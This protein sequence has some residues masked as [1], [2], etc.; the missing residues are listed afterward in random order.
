MNKKRLFLVLLSC[1]PLLLL[2]EEGMWMPNQLQKKEAEMKQLGLRIPVEEIYS[3]V[4]VSLK[5][6]VVLFGGGC[7]GEI[8]SN[9]GLV[10][11]NHHCG[12]S[13]IQSKSTM[14]HNYVQDGF[15]AKS[16]KDELPCPGLTVTFTVRIENVTE[17]ILSALA[18][19]MSPQEREK[20]I[21]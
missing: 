11:T 6:A 19:E 5:D 21:A 18:P 8:I 10:L 9:Q 1:F 17:N 13:Q 16:K 3:E 14:E 2:A 4:N 20:K 15:W 7:T 12:F